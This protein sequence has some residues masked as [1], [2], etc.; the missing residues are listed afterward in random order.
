MGAIRSISAAAPAKHRAGV[1]AAFYV[2]AYLA[3]SV[4]AVIAGLAVP[5]LGIEPT[6]RIFG[7][8][9]I[10]LALLTAAGTHRGARIT[11]DRSGIH[12]M[13]H[14]YGSYPDTTGGEMQSKLLSLLQPDDEGRLQQ[15]LSEEVIFQS[16]VR[17]YHGRAR[18]PT[19]CR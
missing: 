14:P 1:M 7:V 11:P 8:A 2:I 5:G 17:D 16:P 19:S 6:F 13:T 10:V 12:E 15:A 18:W 9:V 4:P 3:L